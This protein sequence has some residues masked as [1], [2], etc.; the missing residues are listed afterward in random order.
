MRIQQSHQVRL[1]IVCA[2]IARSSY[3]C[4]GRANHDAQSRIQVPPGAPDEPSLRAPAVASR[5]SRRVKRNSFCFAPCHASPIHPRLHQ[6]QQTPRL[7]R[8]L[9]ERTPQHLVR[10]PVRQR[11][12]RLRHLDVRQRLAAMRERFV[13]ALVLVQQRNRADQRGTS[14]D[15]AA[16]ASCRP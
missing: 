8:H 15:R 14:C 5:T 11:D 12:I 2:V 3:S 16:C 9:V 10:D 1:A 4:Q 7:R 6:P 13:F